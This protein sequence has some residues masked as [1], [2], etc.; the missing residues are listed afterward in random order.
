MISTNVAFRCTLASFLLWGTLLF[1]QAPAAPGASEPATPTSALVK[2]AQQLNSDGKQDEALAAYQKALE[3][4]PDDADAHLGMGAVLDLKGEYSEAR[5][6][7]SKAIAVASTP[8]AKERAWRTMA[9][10][11]AFECNMD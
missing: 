1:A 3:L 9:F 4:S 10:S 5:K 7:I 11:Y 8:D 6:H 2:Q